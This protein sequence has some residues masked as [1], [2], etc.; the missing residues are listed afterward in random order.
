MLGHRIL[1]VP[2]RRASTQCHSLRDVLLAG[3]SF[4]WIV[5]TVREAGSSRRYFLCHLSASRDVDDITV[6]FRRG[7]STLTCDPSHR[8]FG[9][10]STAAIL[11][12]FAGGFRHAVH[13]EL[14]AENARICAIL[15]DVSCSDCLRCRVRPTVPTLSLI[16]N[17]AEDPTL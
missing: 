8:C 6:G 4:G 7:E 11:A 1:T 3:E 17:F 2:E 9:V 13:D 5:S 14:R 10:T 16:S 12:T 15:L